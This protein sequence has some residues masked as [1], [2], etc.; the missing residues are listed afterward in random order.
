M[1]RESIFKL[2]KYRDALSSKKRQ[3]SD[4]S[5]GERPNGVSGL[6]KLGSQIP[7]NPHGIMTQRL[8]DRAKGVGVSK[9]VR[10]SVADVQVCFLPTFFS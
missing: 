10:T 9:R 6:V 3:R 7:K 4:L 2:D 5:S 1:L 8:E